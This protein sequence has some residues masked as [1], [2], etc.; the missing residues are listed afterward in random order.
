MKEKRE[1]KKKKELLDLCSHTI[2]LSISKVKLW[3]TFNQQSEGASKENKKAK[4]EFFFFYKFEK[5]LDLASVCGESRAEQP[6]AQSTQNRVRFVF[7][8]LNSFIF[9]LMKSNR[10]RGISPYGRTYKLCAW[11]YEKYS[12]CNAT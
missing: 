11:E 5:K 9:L 3:G 1:K 7:I 4:F 8:F 2:S 10:P 6:G 12:W